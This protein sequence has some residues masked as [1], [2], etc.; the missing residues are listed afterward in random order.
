MRK[1]EISCE[2]LQNVI[3]TFAIRRNSRNE[4]GVGERTIALK[5]TGHSYMSKPLL[6]MKCPS[7]NASAKMV[8]PE[9]MKTSFRVVFFGIHSMTIPSL[10]P[11]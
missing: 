9:A 7:Q 8:S 4:G 2:T 11:G 10:N 1:T 3:S 6:G 5:A